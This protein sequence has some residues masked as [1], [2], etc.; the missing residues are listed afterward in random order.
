MN[1][2]SYTH[3]SYRIEQKTQYTYEAICRLQG[4]E[5]SVMLR[6]LIDGF[7]ENNPTLVETVTPFVE[8][9]IKQTDSL[10]SK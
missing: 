8:E 4:I 6:K 2:P 5:P 3:R 1:E 10:S 7:L 9:R